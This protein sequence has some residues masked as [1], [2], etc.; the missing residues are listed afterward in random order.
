MR[1][2]TV[3]DGPDERTEIFEIPERGCLVR[4]VVRGA[5]SRWTTASVCF[6]PGV[7]TADFGAPQPAA[8]PPPA[9]TPAA[10]PP[11]PAAP[12]VAEA[13]P[14]AAPTDAAPASATPAEAPAEP[15]APAPATPAPA[16]A[17]AATSP[18]AELL[19][20]LR[21][22]SAMRK[23]VIETFREKLGLSTSGQLGFLDHLPQVGSFSVPG[24]G[25]WIWRIDPNLATLRSKQRVLELVLPN[26]ARD[27]AFD[28]EAASAHLRATGH[29]VVALEGAAHP[30][31]PA[32]LTELIHKLESAKKVTLFASVP[33]PV[34]IVK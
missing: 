31:D 20:L 13:P 1:W 23:A 29:A 19:G 34:Y 12:P 33:K 25:D 26:H 30:T 11:P 21:G 9:P 17:A 6:C 5:D 28:I 7:R 16:A 8:S 4:I 2:S 18:A 22:Y 27:D 10:A 14:A 24:H 3:A 32:S 15:S